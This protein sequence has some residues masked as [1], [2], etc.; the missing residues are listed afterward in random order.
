V[1]PFDWVVLLLSLAFIVVYGLWKGR[2]SRDLKGYF[3][4]NRSLPWYTIALSIMATQASAITF[5]STPGQAY[6]DGMRFVQFYFGLPLAMIVIAAVIVPIYRRM[7]VITAYE[8]L[9][10]RFDGKT[11]SL[12]ALLFLLQRG[13]AAGLTI[14]APSLILSVLLGWNLYWTNLVIGLLVVSYTAMGG[15]RAVNHTQ[16]QQFL[17]IIG[18]MGL[19]FILI[20]R[21]LP[22]SVG[23]GDAVGIAGTL[24]RL[25]AIDFGFDAGN[26]YNVWSG[27]IG[28]FFLQ[29]SYFGTDQSQVGRYLTGR[30]VADS[31]MSLLFN[32]IV[33][34]P[35]QFVILFLGAMV[36]VFYQFAPPP[37]FFNPAEVRKIEASPHAAEFAEI[38]GRHAKA[39]ET[40]RGRIEA[41][42]EARHTED[43]IRV[44]AAELDVRAAQ[45]EVEQVRGAAVELMK[46]NDPG[47]QTSDTNYIFLTFVLNHLP[48]GVVGL[49]LA[50]IFA[51]SM[52]S[53]AA[54]LNALASTTVVDVYRRMRR[55]RDAAL[56]APE[57]SEADGDVP[58]EAAA[59]LDAHGRHEVRV[60]K[61]ST[62]LWGAFAIGFAEF[63]N[64]LGSLIE[65]IN[66]L[67]SLFYP[68]ILGIFLT[69]FFLKRVGGHAVFLGAIM[70]QAVV[71]YLYLFTG[72]AFLWYNLGCLLVMAFA[73]ALQAAFDARR[74]HAAA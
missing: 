53:T 69:A 4:A 8:Y 7:N 58:G 45:G 24:G 60:S 27:L 25:N 43:P 18:G 56:P 21:G 66:I 6:V 3:L 1:R 46:V 71:V 9:E 20:L 72:I 63:A 59:R 70:A 62:V 10:G 68:T 37:V 35:M 48:V 49:V 19:A 44:A 40:R 39:V 54:E 32:G 14:Y 65:A 17:I 33:K 74:P 15:T 5:L 2:G 50:A 51:A 11:R 34:I 12:A 29:L 31:R 38:Q 73:L 41:M 16:F 57:A 26:R 23:F 55:R 42:I 67:G 30:S 47:A 13:L 64:R 22:S 61:W 28:G 36:F 52:S